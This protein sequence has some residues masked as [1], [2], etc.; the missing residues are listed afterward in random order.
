MIFFQSVLTN[1]TDLLFE[2]CFMFVEEVVEFF[3]GKT[4][5]IRKRVSNLQ[6]VATIK[7]IADGRL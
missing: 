1:L 7:M 5:C 2:L 3:H 4:E 6:K